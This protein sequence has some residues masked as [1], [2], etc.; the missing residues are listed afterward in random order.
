MKLDVY[1]QSLELHK[2]YHGKMETVSKVKLDNR[3]ALSLAYTPGVAEV[4]REIARDPSLATARP[5]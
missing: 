4:C 3:E 2:K 5:Y 1:Q